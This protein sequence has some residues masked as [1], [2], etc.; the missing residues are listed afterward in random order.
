MC[1]LALSN[2]SLSNITDLISSVTNEANVSV[3]SLKTGFGKEELP[4]WAVDIL[5]Y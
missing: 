1:T 5:D 4:D 2:P 3:F